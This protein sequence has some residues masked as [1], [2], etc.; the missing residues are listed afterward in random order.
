MGRRSDWQ[1]IAVRSLDRGTVGPVIK[2]Y[3]HARFAGTLLLHL[4]FVSRNHP[5]FRQQGMWAVVVGTTVIRRKGYWLKGINKAPFGW[6]N[7]VLRLHADG[8]YAKERAAAKASFEHEPERS[9][10]RRTR[11]PAER[12]VRTVDASYEQRVRTPGG[13]AA[14]GEQDPLV[15]RPVARAATPEKVRADGRPVRC[16]AVVDYFLPAQ[17]DELPTKLFP[18]RYHTIDGWLKRAR[19]RGPKRRG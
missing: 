17:Y 19:R 8:T 18:M 4:K 13:E 16:R 6:A 15:S 14:A 3:R 5:R 9:R 7:Q 12:N 2:A 1:N 11:L 10:A